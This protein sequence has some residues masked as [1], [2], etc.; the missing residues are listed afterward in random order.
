MPRLTLISRYLALLLAGM[1]LTACQGMDSYSGRIVFSG[2]HHLDREIAVDGDLIVL[3]GQVTIPAGSR[4]MG[5]VYMV[6]GDLVMDGEVEGDLTILDGNVS[7]GPTSLLLGDLNM[8]SSEVSMHPD[9]QIQGT[10]T[11]GY[12]LPTEWVRQ[13]PTFREQ[14]GSSLV[15]MVLMILL[16]I[17]LKRV[18]P[19]PLGRIKRTV[20]NHLLISITIGALSAVVGLVLFIQLAFTVILI[21]ISIA[22][23]GF[24]LL[25]ITIGWVAL[26][27][28]LADKVEPLLPERVPSFIVYVSC[29]G[30]VS[31]LIDTLRYVP[32]IGTP[33]MLLSASAG[34]GAALLTRLGFQSYS[35]IVDQDLL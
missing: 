32:L 2:S 7:L 4:V 35:P 17:V 9:S 23:L 13:E 22:G 34:I 16:A 12:G 31:I 11:E 14:A 15:Q 20:Q 33:L 24:M 6:G 27:T 28:W 25:L 1:L 3:D 10:T 5:S 29:V 21:P 8:G 30:L 18:L 26:G 19:K